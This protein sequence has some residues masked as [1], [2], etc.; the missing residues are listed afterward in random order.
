MPKAMIFLAVLVIAGVIVLFYF[1][2]RKL[3]GDAV[4]NAPASKKEAKPKKAAA[5]DPSVKERADALLGKAAQGAKNIAGQAAKLIE[6]PGIKLEV[7]PMPIVVE[8]G[9]PASV[10]IT[11]SGGELRPLQLQFFPAAGS[12]LTVTGGEFAQGAAETTFTVEALAAGRDASLTIQAGDE[13]KL[14]VPVRVK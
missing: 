13:G 5:S 6:K 7:S 11:R 9:T 4:E 3:L 12:Q 10:K 1:G 8:A 14:T 2:G